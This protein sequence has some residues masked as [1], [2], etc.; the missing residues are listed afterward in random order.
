MSET[1]RT[2]PDTSPFDGLTP[3]YS[4]IV[5]DPPWQYT[6]AKT[7]EQHTREGR[8][9]AADRHYDTM[10]PDEL[11]ALPVADL[12]ADLAHLYLWVT[13]PKLRLGFDVMDAWG[14]TYQ[15]TLTWVKVGA[16][17]AVI[18]GGLGWYFR[19]ATEHVLFGTKGKAGIPS[20]L[21]K[22]N[23]ITAQRNRHSAKPAEF[24]DLVDSVSPGPSLELFARST[25]PGWDAWG[26]ELEAA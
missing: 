20:G 11:C 4:T 14:F 24:F 1:T 2:A 6:K 9:R 23:V 19:G 3:P 10:T 18:R 12:A 26:N 16:D 21:R 22:P 17:G 5:A 8:G 25:R 13:N 15:T 7:T